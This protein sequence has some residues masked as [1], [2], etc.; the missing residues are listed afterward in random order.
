MTTAAAL[1]C[2]HCGATTTKNGQPYKNR[3]A[4]NTH[5]NMH[6]EKKPLAAETEHK[7]KW[8]LLNPDKQDHGRAIQAGYT[9]HCACGELE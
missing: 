9:K 7:H 4:L 6:C 5:I 3:S 8:A 2:P 1:K